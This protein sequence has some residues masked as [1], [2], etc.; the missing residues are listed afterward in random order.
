MTK[1]FKKIS[2]ITTAVFLFLLT[3]TPNVTPLPPLPGIPVENPTDE[4]PE[5]KP[6]ADDDD[7]T[8]NDVNIYTY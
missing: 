1:L 8:E 7:N 4:E 6:M 3:T 2:I 5:T